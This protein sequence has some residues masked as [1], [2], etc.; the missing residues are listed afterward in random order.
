MVN[1]NIRGVLYAR[2]LL[3]KVLSSFPVSFYSDPLLDSCFAL[4]LLSNRL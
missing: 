4:A 2:I 3:V 1:Q